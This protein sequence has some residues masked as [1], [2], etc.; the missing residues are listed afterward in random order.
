MPTPIPLHAAPAEPAPV[1]Q[2]VRASTDRQCYSTEG[3][4]EANS[5][6]AAEHGMSIV[7]TY[8]DDGRSGLSLRGR[9]GLM[10]LLEDIQRGDSAFKAVLVYD[11]SR[12]GRFQDVDESAFY[13]YLCR[14]AGIR[15][16]YCAEPFGDVEGPLSALIKALKRTM[17]GEYSRELS[18]KV[19]AG[20]CRLVERGYR[21]GGVPGFA[22]RRLLIDAQGEPKGLL[23]QGERKS[24]QSDRVILVP[25]L[26]E[27][28]ALVQRIYKRY[29]D[30]GVSERGI[31]EELRAEGARTEQ[32]KPWC[33]A[34]VKQVLTNPK[35]AGI[36]LYNRAS[37]KLRT[38]RAKNPSEQ[39]VRH[40]EAFAPIVSPERFEAAQRVRAAKAVRLTAGNVL[41][42]LRALLQQHGRLTTDL[43]DGAGLTFKHR[44]VA[45][46]FGSLPALYERLGFESPAK[47]DHLDLMRR[48]NAHTHV[49]L[50]DLVERIRA[51]GVAV[52][53][54]GSS[55]QFELST[56]LTVRLIVH[57]ASSPRGERDSWR[58][59]CAGSPP[60]VFAVY[61]LAPE[62]EVVARF[63]FP[64]DQMPGRPRE[65]D[66]AG[67]Q[68]FRVGDLDDLVCLLCGSDEGHGSTNNSGNA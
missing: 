34:S 26:P 67:A 56:G 64:R 55:P 53:R 35:Y 3:Q 2:Y 50:S 54:V 25:G 40:S 30:D 28:V 5:R 36:N 41:E 31:V 6:Y 43:I 24:L 49:L 33:R 9:P 20:Q 19:F 47:T 29:V 37:F 22:L 1:A 4:S 61:W 16:V 39:W 38:T 66:G 18:S 57:R 8:A 62:G 42:E 14:R 46:R 27:E 17:A 13:E 15:V 59:R 63:L 10:Q 51:R 32:G 68:L 60:G 11:V 23:K 65:L 48:S 52:R 7:R 12:W 58:R 44:V 45:A 21:Q